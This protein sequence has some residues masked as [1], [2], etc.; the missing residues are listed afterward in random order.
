LYWLA[1]KEF[2]QSLDKKLITAW[3]LWL[4]PIIL[5]T[6]ETDIRMIVFPGEPTEK[7]TTSH[8][9]RKKKKLSIV[10][11]AYHPSYG[12]KHKTGALWQRLA[13]AKC[14]TLSPK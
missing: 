7:F 13:W 14:E 9:N 8:L 2:K 11:C 4:T 5:A 10:A 6:W 1:V 12:R 3:H